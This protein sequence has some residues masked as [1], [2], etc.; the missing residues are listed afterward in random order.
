MNHENNVV[1]ASGK[2]DNMPK[3]YI[4][5]P[6]TDGTCPR[7]PH[8]LR[9]IAYRQLPAT[10]ASAKPGPIRIVHPACIVQAQD[11]CGYY[12]DSTPV[13]F[14]R[15]MTTLFED[16]PLKQ[17]RIVRRKVMAC[18]SCESYFYQS[19][20]GERLISPDEQK[21]IERA[22]RS[23]GV[24]TAPQYDGYEEGFNW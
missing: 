9:A 10:E 14:A 12:R 24:E 8:C 20:K 13:R 22:F 4:Y 5:C 2:T 6:A 1:A 15:G 16:L 19:R 21:A 7:A 17:A 3:D 23:A 11:G 18:F